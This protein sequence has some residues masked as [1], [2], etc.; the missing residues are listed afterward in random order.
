MSRVVIEFLV[1]LSFAVSVGATLAWVLVWLLRLRTTE[2]R[3]PRPPAGLSDEELSRLLDQ[4]EE[5]EPG[6]KP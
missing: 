5:A 2:V 3:G 4:D 1:D 6:E